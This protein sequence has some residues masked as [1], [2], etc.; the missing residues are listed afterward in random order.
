MQKTIFRH[1]IVAAFLVVA[2]CGSNSPG[3]TTGT[4]GAGGTGTGG[5]TGGGSGTGGTPA[6][7]GAAGGASGG[8]AG[9]STGGTAGIGTGGTAGAGTGGTAGTGTG[10]S[11][12]GG[13][14]GAALWLTLPDVPPSLAVPAGATLVIHDHGI[15][16][17]IYTCTPSG[18]ADAGADAG[19][20]TYAWVL[21]APDAKLYDS[22]NTQVGTHGAGPEWTSTVDGS[23]VNGTKVL[24]AN[25]PVTGAIPWL[26]LRA[27][28]TSGTGVFTNITYIQRVNTVG[29]VAPATGCGA[30]TS[31]TQTSVAYSADYYF[32]TGGG[33]AAWLVP[34]G[35]L[36]SAIAVP[37]GNKLAIHDRGIGNQV[38]TCTQTGGGDAGAVSYGW[39]LKGP[40]AILYNATFAQ[41]G[42]HGVGPEWTSTDGSVVN[43][44]KLG[45]A[46]GATTTAVAW[47]LLKASSTTGTGV[48]TNVTYVQRL[49]TVGGAAPATG[50][51]AGTVSTETSV[52]YSA[53]YYFFIA[54]TG[55]GGVGG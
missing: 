49:N 31:G 41:V 38:Y 25:A 28:S 43:G 37:T 15:G 42:T 29:G 2:G 24:Q 17:Q 1:G 34:P 21:K 14:G 13:V 36:P 46:S 4:G 26:L 5:A 47:L 45:Q 52:A 32:Y 12:G 19:A 8:T 18:G 44:T 16:T 55:D 35:N 23:V 6:T 20:I 33:V 22:T 39:V 11:G 10:G 40:D 51:S 48:F 50:C 53:D 9:A 27:S 3:G 54:G 7:G 30:S